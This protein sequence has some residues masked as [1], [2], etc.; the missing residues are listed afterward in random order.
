MICEPCAQ[1]NHA[2]CPAVEVV[3]PCEGACRPEQGE[4]CDGTRKPQLV[5]VRSTWCPCQHRE[6]IR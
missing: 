1:G 5:T 2:Q 3:N 4:C 6:A